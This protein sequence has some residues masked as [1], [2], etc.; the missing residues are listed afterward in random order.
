MEENPNIAKEWDYKKNKGLLPENYTGGS[1]K[2]VWWHC[3]RGH[4]WLAEINKR[5]T[6]GRGCPYCSG[7]KVWPGYNDIVTTHPLIAAQW[8]YE[9]NG[10]YLPE[11]F[12]IGVDKKF[13]WKCVCGYSWQALAYSRKKH[14]CPACARNI[15][16]TGVNDLLTINPTLAAEWDFVKNGGII[17]SGVAANDSLSVWWLCEYGH[18]WQ[19][20]ISSRNSGKGCPYCANRKLLTGFNDLLTVAPELAA[21]WHCEKNGNLRPEGVLAG[22]HRI[23]WWIC[24]SG[25]EWQAKISNRRLGTGCPYDA[26]KL[27]IFGVNDLKT[28]R[29]DLTAEWDY[30]KNGIR[31]PEHVT[32]QSHWIVWWICPDRGHSYKA[33]VSNRYRGKGCPFCAG[34]RPFPGETDF[35]TVHPELL[36]EWDFEKN[37]NLRPEDF[38][39]GSHK[40]IWWLCA[41][42]HSWKTQIYHRHIGCG[43]QICAKLADNHPVVVGVTDLAAVNPMVA[44][45]WDYERN[46]DLTPQ[47]VLPNSNITVWWKCRRG[48]HWKTRIQTR[49]KGTG[50]PYCRGKTPMRIRLV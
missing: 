9:K 25:H 24:P 10:D 4:S 14:G 5:F 11:Q 46:G 18:S 32:A 22:S 35:A 48:H 50:C 2:K 17:P 39:V 31:L 16:I 49:A 33:S 47:D 42:G 20:V 7:N 3:A 44:S 13:W 27:A 37:G 28:L 23:V 19:A 29:P 21:Q 38:T 12:S 6:Y 15:L 45:E 30:E 1:N 26:G 43:C 40:K 36:S 41:Y 8:D 34:K